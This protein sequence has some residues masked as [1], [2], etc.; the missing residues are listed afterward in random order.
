MNVVICTEHRASPMK[1]VLKY[2]VYYG[3]AQGIGSCNH[4]VIACQM[5]SF[6]MLPMLT[7][8]AM[9]FVPNLRYSF[10]G[11]QQKVCL[12]T[13][14]CES[15]TEFAV[16]TTIWVHP[17][18]EEE[19]RWMVN[20]CVESESRSWMMRVTCVLRSVRTAACRSLFFYTLYIS[21]SNLQ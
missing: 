8:P 2:R 4:G 21:A 14:L 15:S 6:S 9:I 18:F 11:N 3:A 19:T 1:V 7:T 10:L 5:V 17:D 16:F 20:E 13:C 12:L